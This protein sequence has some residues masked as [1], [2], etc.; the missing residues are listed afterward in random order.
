MN[1]VIGDLHGEISKLKILIKTIKK[2]TATPSFI[3][4]GDYIDKG[5]NSKRTL[6]YL[7]RLKDKHPTIFLMGNHEYYWFNLKK[8][9]DLILKYGG[10]KT[11]KDFGFNSIENCKKLIFS[12]YSDI[13]AR[14]RGC[15]ETEKYF[16]SHSGMPPKKFKS[17]YINKRDISLFLFNRY[18]F[19]KEQNFFK[20]KKIFIFGHTA[21]YSPYVDKYKI[22][23]DTGPCYSNKQPLTSFCIETESFI[24][25]R[26]S[27]YELKNANYNNCPLII[28]KDVYK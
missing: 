5:E 6:D 1:F 7:I 22:G 15:F 20:K 14:L 25:S 12:Q 13:F 11:V 19:I 23:I 10:L 8:Y 16:I 21:F 9:K 26:G 28:R 17:E 3:F 27:V 2:Q 24:D 18:D 4:L